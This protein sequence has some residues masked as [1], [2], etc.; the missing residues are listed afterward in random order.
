[1]SEV[2]LGVLLL[3]FLVF[4]VWQSREWAKERLALVN[5]I[6]AAPGQVIALERKTKPRPEPVALP[7][8]Y[9]GQSGL[10]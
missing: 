8:G 6:I 4:H 10:S 9:E 2:V 7:D 5:R 3:T 1:M